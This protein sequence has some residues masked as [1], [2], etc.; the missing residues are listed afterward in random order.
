M[1]AFEII[2]GKKLKG[3]LE[4]RG[5]KNEALEI[6]CAALLTPEKVTVRNI[7]DIR[8]THSLLEILKGL[9]VKVEQHNS[10]E[11][12]FQAD[13]L[14]LDYLRTPE[15][16]KSFGNIRG[17]ILIAGPLLARF[18]TVRIPHLGGDKIG[19]RPLDT[20]FF[21]L[22]KIG[23]KFEYIPE[24][25]SY[26]L[27]TDQLVGNSILLEEASVTGTANLIMAASLSQGTTIIYNA[28][29]EPHVQQLCRMLNEMGARI[30]GI[31]SNLLTI[32]GVF[33]LHGCEHTILPDLIEVGSFI[34]LAAATQSEITVTNAGCEHLGPVLP[35]FE[36]L[37]ICIEI[38]GD[39]I[40]VPSQSLC[41]IAR[42]MDGSIFSVADGPWPG[43][44]ADLMS[45]ALVAAIHARGTVLIHEKMYESRL[46]FV[47][48]LIDM[49]AQIILCDPH[50]ATI[51]G[52][53]RT[54]S[55]RGNTIVSPDIRAGIALLIA[56]LS[57]EGKSIMYNI[58]QIERG[59]EK[60]DERLRAIGAEIRR[61]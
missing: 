48:R 41:T 47:D 51:I 37:G 35:M 1:N 11:Y 38:R 25:R 24:E 50:R 29:C 16:E 20:H 52:L 13:S 26:T 43:F 56:A 45:I 19:K 28:A 55:L 53:D 15:C 40:H 57:A 58:E 8:D 12:T 42:Q 9:G 4:P 5:S 21:G 17:A 10:H 34:G 44:P 7:P 23:G 27:S 36:R 30:T 59:Y 49:G 32:H 54:R 18:K 33:E 60:I 22:E 2:G 39:D 14:N 46:F 3:T 6:L 61:V 31:G